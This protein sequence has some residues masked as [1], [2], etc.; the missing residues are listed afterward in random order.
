MQKNSFTILK[1]VIFAYSTANFF[2][3]SAFT[4]DLLRNWNFHILFG[5]CVDVTT[6][7]TFG[8]EGKKEG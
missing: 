1:Y 3:L 6:G 4:A 8:G 5:W 7:V 2:R